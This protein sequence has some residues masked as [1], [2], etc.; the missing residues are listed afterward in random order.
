MGLIGWVMKDFCKIIMYS[1]TFDD[2]I[3]ELIDFKFIDEINPQLNEVWINPS[4]W[5]LL[6]YREKEEV[7]KF[8][9]VYCGMKKGTDKHLVEIKD[10]Y[11]GKKIAKYDSSGFEIY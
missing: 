2:I 9:A 10:S 6:K 4:Q 11:T 3:K 7:A 5:N 8:L 1:P